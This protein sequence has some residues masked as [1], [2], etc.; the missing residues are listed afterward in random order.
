MAPSTIAESLIMS[1]KPNEVS[2][3]QRL[4]KCVAK[5]TDRFERI[6]NGLLAGMP[7]VNYCMSGYEGWIEIKAPEEPKREATPLFGSNHPVSIEQINWM[8]T[9]H[10]AM[11]QSWLFIA[12]GVRVML[13]HG[14]RI[15]TVR[16]KVNE[17]S[18][19][20]LES[21]ACW[22]VKGIVNFEKWIDLRQLLCSN[23]R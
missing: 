15:A 16:G 3:F 5:P 12:T 6:E 13:I 17:M 4:K 21:I 19:A 20:G 9:Q 8:H 11:G 18:V 22:T 2:A 14:G 23:N 7:D 10:M 1:M